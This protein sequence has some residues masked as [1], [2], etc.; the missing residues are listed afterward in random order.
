MFTIHDRDADWT[1]LA[2]HCKNIHLIEKLNRNP[3]G[4]SNIQM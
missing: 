2:L 3:L 4:I 1:D